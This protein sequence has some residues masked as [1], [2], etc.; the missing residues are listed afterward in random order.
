LVG[1]SNKNAFD[2]GREAFSEHTGKPL[3]AAHNNWIV[4]V[5]A[6]K[7]R[8][9]AGWWFTDDRY[10]CSYPGD[11]KSAPRKRQAGV[12]KAEK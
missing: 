4:G 3:Y 12:G 11:S 5:A 1:N 7:E 10:V 2:L 9:K 8:Q 6:K